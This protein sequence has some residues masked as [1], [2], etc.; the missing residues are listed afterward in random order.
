VR[1]VPVHGPGA[2]RDG[3]TRPAR[4]TCAPWTRQGRATA[5]ADAGGRPSVPRPQR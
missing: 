5:T 2:C 4:W 1:Q 3:Q